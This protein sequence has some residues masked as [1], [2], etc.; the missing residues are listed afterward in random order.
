MQHP[1]CRSTDK[2][3]RPQ[4]TCRRHELCG[5]LP[6]FWGARCNV[7]AS[8]QVLVKQVLVKQVLVK[9]VLVKQES[10]VLEELAGLQNAVIFCDRIQFLSGYFLR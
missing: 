3:T 2:G 4:S 7:S 8:C 9:Q 1:Y 5:L 10:L 6:L